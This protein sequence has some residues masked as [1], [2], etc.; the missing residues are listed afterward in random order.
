MKDWIVDRRWLVGLLAAGFLLVFTGLLARGSDDAAPDLMVR[1]GMGPFQVTVTST[2]ELQ[3]KSSVAIKGPGQARRARIYE[4]QILRMIPEGTVVKQG[5]FVAELDRSE[6]TSRI[7]DEEIE[8][9][10]ARSQYEQTALD[11]A[12]TLSQARNEQINLRYAMEEAQLVM[13]QSAYEAPSIRR[14]AEIDYD[15]AE[16]AYEQAVA[17]YETQR[18]QAEA[19][20]REVGAELEKAR[21]Q[22]DEMVAMSDEFTILAPEQG[23]VI[24]QRTRGGG[25]I[26]EGSTVRVWNPVVATLPDLS[27]MES[28]T[29]INEVDIQ[30]VGEGQQVRIGLDA[31]PD[32]RLNGTVTQVANVGEQ[33]PGSD[34]KV[35]RVAIEVNEAD[36]TLR[37]AMTTSNTI[38]VDQVPE[39]VHVP[40]ETIHATDSL[41]YVFVRQG[42]RT[43]RQ[44]VQLGLINENSAIIRDGLSREDRIFL[45]LPADTA[46]MPLQRLQES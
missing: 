39:A 46:G 1:P 11:T 28:I 18:Q 4:M 3:A 30:K 38:I 21:R 33:R 15:K 23:M 5:D 17:N 13:E 19:Q 6:L 25:K 9:D 22:Y 32:K 41:T 40:L 26:T 31:D 12:L 43:V 8:L 27:V 10:Q 24:Y 14:Q 20:M 44:E 37:P 7:Q 34:A 36:T 29:Y 45:T 35:F 42:G 2:G 16:R